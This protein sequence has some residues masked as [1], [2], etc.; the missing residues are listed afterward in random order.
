MVFESLECVLAFASYQSL[1]SCHCPI[2]LSFRPQIASGALAGGLFRCP[3]C[4]HPG[5]TTLLYLTNMHGWWPK[6]SFLLLA[7]KVLFPPYFHRTVKK[8]QRKSIKDFTFNY[9]LLELVERTL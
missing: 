2:G 5:K 3:T 4:P 8:R 1:L 9:I 6:S 7:Q